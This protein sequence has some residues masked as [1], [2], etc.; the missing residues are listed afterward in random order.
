M[1]RVFK[2]PAAERDLIDIY[3]Y[4]AADA[5]LHAATFLRRLDQKIHLLADAPGIGS[6]RLPAYP[7]VRL[8]PV[9]NYLIIYRPLEEDEGIEL[10][11]VFHASRDW[12]TLL[13]EDLS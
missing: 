5:P 12:L 11:R 10:I 9:G 8:F 7:E 13:D 6:S 1:G 4:I 2:R 3:R